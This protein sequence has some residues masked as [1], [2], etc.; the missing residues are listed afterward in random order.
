MAS[1]E[2]VPRRKRAW[3]KP[4]EPITP[5]SEDR[6]ES[7]TAAKPIKLQRNATKT[8]HTSQDAITTSDLE[9]VAGPIPLVKHSSETSEGAIGRGI[10]TKGVATTMDTSPLNVDGSI[11]EGVRGNFMNAPTLALSL[12][13]WP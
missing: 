13:L 8:T 6:G 1:N 7:I 11:M 9:K 3:R 5:D 10:S 2:G 12:A 4:R